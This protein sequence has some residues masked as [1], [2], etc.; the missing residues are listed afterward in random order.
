M[1]KVKGN[2]L[3]VYFE[4][5]HLNCFIRVCLFFSI[6]CIVFVQIEL[7]WFGEGSS[8]LHNWIFCLNAELDLC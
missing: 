8:A 2:K 4:M 3:V 7:L 1:N 5:S 6:W